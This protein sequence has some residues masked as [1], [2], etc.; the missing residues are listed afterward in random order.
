MLDLPTNTANEP[1]A[2]SDR[3]LRVLQA[4]AR[5][6]DDTARAVLELLED[7]AG[8][9]EDANADLAK[10]FFEW[11]GIHAAIDRS[12]SLSDEELTERCRR[13]AALEDAA[14]G[15]PVLGVRDVWRKNVMALS[16]LESGDEP[17]SR[18]LREV[19]AALGLPVG[20]YGPRLS[21]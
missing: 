9:G 10:L 1:R 16:H 7:A 21:Q 11:F 19:Q 17:G 3:D 20:A 14:A 2:M 5:L 4:V 13:L 15:M 8:K 18:L 6:P 12:A